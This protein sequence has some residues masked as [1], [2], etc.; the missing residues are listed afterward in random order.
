MLWSLQF[1]AETD[2]VGRRMTALLVPLL[3]AIRS[4]VVAPRARGGDP[5]PPTSTRRPPTPGA[6]SV[7]IV[8]SLSGVNSLP[9]I[10]D[11]RNVRCDPTR[12]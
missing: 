9:A 4:A 3:A 5:R 7:M 2:T 1:L 11:L 10:P 6:I 12:R 8:S